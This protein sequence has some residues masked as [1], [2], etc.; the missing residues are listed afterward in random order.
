MVKEWHAVYTGAQGPGEMGKVEE[1]TPIKRILVIGARLVG[2]LDAC[3][4]VIRVLKQVYI[5]SLVE[6]VVGWLRRWRAVEV[7]DVPETISTRR[8]SD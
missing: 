3:P 4:S 5:R 6:A 7:M 8:R 2:N 1:L